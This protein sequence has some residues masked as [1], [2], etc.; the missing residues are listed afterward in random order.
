MKRHVMSGKRE[1]RVM[2][3]EKIF[4]YIGCSLYYCTKKA[5]SGK[6]IIFL[7]GA[8][9]DHRMFEE[10]VKIV[11][12][13]YNILIWDA[14]SHGKSVPNTRK[15]SMKQLLDDLLK[16]MEI[17]QIQKAI[18]I[19]Q[20]MGGNLSQEIAYYHPDKVEGL[21]LIDCTCN[22]A[23][24]SLLDKMILSISKPMF[25]LYPW[26]TLV[27]QSADACG[28]RR[29]VKEYVEECFIKVGKETFIDILIEV[30]KCLHEDKNYKIK[31]PFLL[32]CGENDPTGNIR[33]I[34]EPW[35]ASEPNCTYYMISNS[36]HNSNQD[37]PD[38]VNAH[39]NNFLRKLYK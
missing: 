26:K 32:L 33:K 12:Q 14:R 3:E 13:E 36:G 5:I 16:I 1:V 23:K 10:Q 27:R 38:E 21:V 30:T 31:V 39:I 11:P 7:H 2:F 8:G 28:M 22:T 37:N 24:L 29:E 15:F 6:W 25:I 18:F 35:S 20:S 17:E 9:V 4:E 34:A 19:G